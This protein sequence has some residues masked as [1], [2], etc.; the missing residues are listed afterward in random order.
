M[1][2]ETFDNLRRNAAASLMSEKDPRGYWEGELSSSALSTATAITAL[3]FAG[4]SPELIERGLHWLSS[5]AN[6]DGG[7]TDC[8]L[9]C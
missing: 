5:N 9:L 2:L 3:H 4:D 7:C 6:G 8:C 1:D